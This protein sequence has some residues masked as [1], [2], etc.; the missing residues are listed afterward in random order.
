MLRN[1]F[2]MLASALISAPL[3][4]QPATMTKTNE[5]TPYLLDNNTVVKLLCGPWMGTGEYVGNGIIVTARHVVEGR[6]CYADGQE[7]KLV[8]AS[9]VPGLDFAEVTVETVAPYRQ[10]I[11]CSGF[12]E[13]Q[14]LL[15]S[16]YAEDAPR[17]VTQRLTASSAT[18]VEKGFAGESI[19]R[20]SI[21]QGMSGGPIN[22]LNTGALVGIVNAN[23]G[24]GIT[25]VLSVPLSKTPLCRHA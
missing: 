18:T 11:D 3:Q 5:P 13:G 20:G 12:H 7:A 2:V 25:S 24:D 8:K 6:K 4:F 10:L 23:S 22:D 1:A 21:T 9:L 17:T 16:G 15:A 14:Q 19:L